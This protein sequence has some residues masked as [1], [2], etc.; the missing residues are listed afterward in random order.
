MSIERNTFVKG[1]AVQLEPLDVPVLLP[2][3]GLVSLRQLLVAHVGL[4]LLEDQG[5]RRRGLGLAGRVVLGE[6]HAV[7]LG[8]Y[9]RVRPALLGVHG[10]GHAVRA[11][12]GLEGDVGMDVVLGQVVL[13]GC[14][15]SSSVA[16]VGRVDHGLAAVGIV[17]RDLVGVRVALGRGRRELVG[18]GVLESGP[19]SGVV[20]AGT[21]VGEVFLAAVAAHAVMIG[22]PGPVLE[23]PLEVRMGV[24]HVGVPL[25]GVLSLP[26]LL[27]NGE[28]GLPGLGVV[29]LEVMDLDVL[30]AR[31]AVPGVLG[32]LLDPLVCLDELQPG[33]LSHCTYLS[34]AAYGPSRPSSPGRTRAAACPARRR[35]GAGRP[36]CRRWTI[37]C[38]TARRCRSEGLTG[39]A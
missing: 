14:P 1:Y 6:V 31:R 13:V 5:V 30:R 22:V 26:V 9:R 3:L 34:S 7:S 28:D 38:P 12:L 33:I 8:A 37:P 17:E 21:V 29:E 15:V 10:L 20:E 27:V 16:A 11:S 23:G 25:E 19:S 32:L 4:T 35:R 39:S 2:D 36:P 24:R 18:E